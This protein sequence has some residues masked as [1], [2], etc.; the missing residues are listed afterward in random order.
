MSLQ[1]VVSHSIGYSQVCPSCRSALVYI[2]ECPD[3]R[4]GG[5]QGTMECARCLAVKYLKTAANRF[6]H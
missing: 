5:V 3:C 2:C 1:D 4:Q 6:R